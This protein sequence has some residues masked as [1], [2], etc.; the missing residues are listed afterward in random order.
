MPRSADFG[1][2]RILD[3]RHIADFGGCGGGSCGGSVDVCEE[4]EGVAVA[5]ESEVFLALPDC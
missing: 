5:P 2:Q 3:A 4:V 1:A